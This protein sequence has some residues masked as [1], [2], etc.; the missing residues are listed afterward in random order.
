MISL[1]RSL[2]LSQRWW[3]WWWE[4][5]RRWCWWHYAWKRGEVCHEII[6]KMMGTRT[7]ILDKD[8]TCPTG[9]SWGC[10]W[11]APRSPDQH[12]YPGR[13]SKGCSPKG[14]VDLTSQGCDKTQTHQIEAPS[15]LVIWDIW[16]GLHSS[17]VNHQPTNR[18][19]FQVWN[20]RLC[21]GL[22][23]QDIVFLNFSLQVWNGALCA[24]LISGIKQE[25]VAKPQ[26]KTKGWDDFRADWRQEYSNLCSAVE[27]YYSLQNTT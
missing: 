16:S 15:V 6:N 25:N 27:R 2:F 7:R 18:P 3:W 14:F 11:E 23:S 5:W 24:E 26:K 10:P 9:K 19:W 20:W 12:R 21:Q 1:S 13:S 4:C 8:T 22:I 17:L